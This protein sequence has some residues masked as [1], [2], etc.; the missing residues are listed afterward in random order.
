M[1]REGGISTDYEAAYKLIGLKQ[2]PQKRLHF[3]WG[4]YVVGAGRCS[5]TSREEDWEKKKREESFHRSSLYREPLVMS[6]LVSSSRARVFCSPLA[7]EKIFTN[8][9]P[10]P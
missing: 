9:L 2:F 10:L 3:L 8:S 1:R 6:S 7:L 5:L 4:E